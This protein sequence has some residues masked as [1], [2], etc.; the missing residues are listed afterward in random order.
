MLLSMQSK[1]N[2]AILKPSVSYCLGSVQLKDGTIYSTNNSK[3]SNIFE[4]YKVV[5][6]I[7]KQFEKLVGKKIVIS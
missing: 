5:A 2:T 7:Q 4:T 6:S 3:M 1:C